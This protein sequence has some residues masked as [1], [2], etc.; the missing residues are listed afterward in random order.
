LGPIYFLF[1]LAHRYCAA[2]DSATSHRHR[3]AC[4][5]SVL[6]AA[7]IVYASAAQLRGTCWPTKQSDY[8]RF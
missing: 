2:P 4:A 3:D 8:R 6:Q 5:K 7:F 1:G